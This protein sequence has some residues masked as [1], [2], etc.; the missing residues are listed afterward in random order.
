MHDV[1]GKILTVVFVA[2]MWHCMRKCN[3][4]KDTTFHQSDPFYESSIIKDMMESRQLSKNPWYKLYTWLGLLSA[5]L[6]IYLFG[7]CW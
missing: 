5:V 2:A 3:Q 4:I 1:I 7:E 6:A